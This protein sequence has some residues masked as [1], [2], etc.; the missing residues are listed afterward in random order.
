MWTRGVFAQNISGPFWLLEW[1]KNREFPS[2]TNNA[3]S[4]TICPGH[5]PLSPSVPQECLSSRRGQRSVGRNFP[6]FRTVFVIN[7]LPRFHVHTFLL[8]DKYFLL[9]SRLGTPL[10]MCVIVPAA[11]FTRARRLL[12]GG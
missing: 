5:C 3:L 7:D 10:G 8:I 2:G 9:F 12:A 6:I 11:F 1:I 4:W